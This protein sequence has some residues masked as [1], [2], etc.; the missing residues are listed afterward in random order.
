MVIVLVTVMTMVTNLAYAVISGIVVSALLYSW[1]SGFDCKV[2]KEYI[3][4]AELIKLMDDKDGDDDMNDDKNEEDQGIAIYHF[5]GPIFFG[6]CRTLSHYFS[7][8]TDPN[9]IEIHLKDS[10]IYDYSAMQA[11]NSIAEKYKKINKTVHLRHINLKSHKLISKANNLVKHFTYETYEDVIETKAAGD[12]TLEE[13][14]HLHVTKW[15]EQ[16]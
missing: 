16:K 1:E 5:D 7:P 15:G 12:I 2:Q 9:V 3:P 14:D 13:P 10:N 4:P 11:L 6:N 8:E